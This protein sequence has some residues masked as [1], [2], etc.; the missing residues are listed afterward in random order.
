MRREGASID[1]AR[2]PLVDLVTEAMAQGMLE[3]YEG[4]ILATCL[5]CE[6]GQKPY[7]LLGHKYTHG[8]GESGEVIICDAEDIHALKDSL[9][10]ETASVS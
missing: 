10:A 4:A 9:V 3:G 8:A 6:R 2:A 7:R 5:E 1:H